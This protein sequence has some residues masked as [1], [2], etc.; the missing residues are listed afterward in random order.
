MTRHDAIVL[1]VLVEILAILVA[2]F[3][4]L[5]RG[6][7]WVGVV[8]SLM[9]GLIGGL[10]A[11]NVANGRW[12]TRTMHGVLTGF[13][14]GLLFGVTLWFGMRSIIPRTDHSALWGISYALSMHPIGIRQLPWLYTGN[15]LAVLL[16]LVPTLLFAVEGYI[17]AGVAPGTNFSKGP[18]TI[19]P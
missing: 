17:A 6:T 7:G 19:P 2:N 11:G 18:P 10:V 12:Q 14:G 16:V 13:I 8:L 4:P 9:I 15:T 5:P 1:G 3:I